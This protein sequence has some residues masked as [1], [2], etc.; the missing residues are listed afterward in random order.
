LCIQFV[1]AERVAVVVSFPDDSV[2]AECVN[3]A[4][5]TDGYKV[6]ESTELDL[7]WAG[8]SSFG[9]QL[10]EVNGVGD[11]VQGNNCAYS[12]NY[13]GFFIADNEAWEYMPVGFDGGSS[14]WNNDVHSFNGHYCA[15]DKDVIGFR[16]GEYGDKPVY[17]S[18]NSICNPL[19]IKEIK[20]YVDNTSQRTSRIKAY[21]G[22]SVSI[23]VILENDFQF[24]D[25]LEVEELEAEIEVE[26]LGISAIKEFKDIKSGEKDD[27]M[28]RFVIPEST[29]E[30]EFE[31]LV[32]VTGQTSNGIDQEIEEELDIEIGKR[33]E[34]DEI[35]EIIVKQENEDVPIVRSSQVNKTVTILKQPPKNIPVQKSFFSIYGILLMLACFEVFIFMGIVL[36]V[37]AMRK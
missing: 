23:K 2:Y 8:P 19:Y 12:G 33:A 1:T 10:C 32:T 24:D 31:I 5:N 15:S 3:V 26:E 36:V 35:E 18:F 34:R 21:P 30:G 9:H 28:F 16:Y 4:K 29:E 14:C 20:A 13:W 37:I 27:E 7:T 11:N 25:T 6:L 22:A 17:V